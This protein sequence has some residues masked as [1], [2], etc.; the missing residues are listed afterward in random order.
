MV[1]WGEKR[2][3]RAYKG[4]GFFLADFFIDDRHQGTKKAW[5]AQA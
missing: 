2:K 1:Y 3:I 5:K 4:L